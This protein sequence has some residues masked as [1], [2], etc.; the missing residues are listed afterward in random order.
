MYVEYQMSGAVFTR[1]VRNRLRS[2][3]IALD[4]SFPDRQRGPLV[5][6]QVVIG[7]ATT[8]QLEQAVSNAPGGPKTINAATQQVRVFSPTMLANLTVPYMQVKQ[9]IRV[10][11]VL[12]SD[13]EK[14]GPAATPPVLIVTVFPVFNV[15]LEPDA[16]N[17]GSAGPLRLSYSL[18]YVDFGPFALDAIGGVAIQS[19]IV[20]FGALT[21]MLGRPVGAINAGIACDP[22]GT[23]VA[24]R[25]DFDVY[26]S[27]PAV[28]RAFFELGPSD[29]LAGKDW[30]VLMDGNALAQ[31]GASVVKTSL[32]GKANLRILS[33]PS[34]AWYADDTTMAITTEIRLL[35][36]CPN[37]V[38]DTNMDA[39]VEIAVHFMVNEP[40]KLITHY[41]IGSEL[42][43]GDQI[44]PC[45]LTATLLYPFAGAA[46]FEQKNIFLQDY[47][48]GIAFGPFL[49]MV[50]LLG[51]LNGQTLE[52]DI[53]R[54]LGDTCH[55]LNDSEYQ[56]TSAVDMV[57]QLVPTLN[58]KF[59]LTSARGIA[60]G[61]V[62]SGPVTNLGELF[63]G[64]IGEIGIR[65]F[66]W[67]VLGACRGNGKNNFHIG[68]EAKIVV[69]FTSSPAMILKARIMDDDQNG[70]ALS[71][72]DNEITVTPRNPPVS[73]PCRM[74][75]ITNRGVRTLTLAPAKPITG[76]EEQSLEKDLVGAA[77]TCYY[78]EKQF[79][80]VEKILWKIDPALHV[81]HEGVRQWQILLQGLEPGSALTVRTPDGNAVASGRPS[82][83]GSLHL[84]L[85]FDD[86]KAPGEL[87]LELDRAPASAVEVSVQQTLY[88]RRAS[89]P[90]QGQVRRIEF[91]GSLRRPSL[92]VTTNL[93]TLR[94]DVRVPVA[95]QL[96]E[97]ATRESC[98]KPEE[99]E[100]WILH[101]GC[102][103]GGSAPT[104]LI[105]AVERLV[106]HLG[107][108]EAVG[109]RHLRGFA[110]A[111]Y[112]RTEAGAAIYD[113]S[114]PENP[115]VVHTLS[116]SGW[117]ENTAT[118]STLMARHDKARSEI[119]LYE[120]VARH[121]V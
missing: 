78:W 59:V 44:I 81:I 9:E 71:I 33:D 112:L 100:E 14:N 103:T 43:N 92:G 52:D 7:D 57:V 118:S 6:D 25:A 120:V 29:L 40:N 75:L 53:S 35:G 72:K 69:P 73:Y 84:S 46:L 15:K 32:D 19:S 70:Y 16:V 116:S 50:Q 55:K 49:I 110:E 58:S 18:A 11:L 26:A 65:P 5:I 105:T 86:R 24:L 83:R 38:D 74:R 22:A 93:Q 88:S 91:H 98:E 115:Q 94:W 1:V 60:E 64:S 113:I 27:P 2:I 42:T 23:R 117:F 68:N 119:D 34:G 12:A 36:A 54:S 31:R 21:R 20:D 77:L 82:A 79:T 17:A 104:S 30:A 39:R 4:L 111:L 56:C 95:P 90:V 109:L 8:L 80:P 101:N 48:G 41:Q 96:L 107:Q 102:D 47:F 28:S 10:L 99:Q 114:I 121:T 37:F 62:L 45:T 63:T 51:L 108:V 66:K 85:I 97:A 67:Q 13:L 87:S 3:P 106:G 61:L 76:A 89:L